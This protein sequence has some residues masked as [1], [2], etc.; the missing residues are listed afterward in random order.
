MKVSECMSRDI[1]I[2]SPDHTLQSAAQVMADAD[3]GFLPVG[4]ADRLVGTVTDRDIAIRGVARGL[5]PDSPLSDVMSKQLLYCFEDEETD[6]AL[7][8]MSENQ[9]RRMPVVNRDK[10]LVG[11]ISLAD[12]AREGQGAPAGAALGDIARPRGAKATR[13]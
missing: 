10:R 9:V 8:S 1:R 4:E 5:A 11:I 2:C 6:Q 3:A 12:M 13:S 7:A